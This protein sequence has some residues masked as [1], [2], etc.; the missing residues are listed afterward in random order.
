M[1]AVRYQSV[2]NHQ[3][4][5]LVHR[6][7]QVQVYN[8][9]FQQCPHLYLA[10]HCHHNLG[11]IHQTHNQ[12]LYHNQRVRFKFIYTVKPVLSDHSKIRQKIGFRYL[13]LHK[14]GQKYCRMLVE[15]S[16]MLLTFIKLSFVFKTFVLPNFE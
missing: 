15:H 5:P 4:Q 1:P 16:V 8:Q 13:L 14:A 7:L 3:L 11:F 12:H 9:E 6:Q 10:A 2:H